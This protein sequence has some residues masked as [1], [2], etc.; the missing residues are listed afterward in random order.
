M[1]FY[2][3]AFSKT[4]TSTS[5]A[6]AAGRTAC[7]ASI[8]TA[9]GFRGST[10]TGATLPFRG[11]ARRLPE[12]HW[13]FDSR[14]LG[15]IGVLALGHNTERTT[16][17]V[18]LRFFLL[19]FLFHQSRKAGGVGAGGYAETTRE[20]LPYNCKLVNVDS[21]ANNNIGNNSARHCAE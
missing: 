8:W 10:T 6:L 12:V 20:I 17:L 11:G 4:I 15:T 1:G 16:S 13:G 18:C 9:A 7:R 19:Y 3:R 14:I 2:S 21:H 5:W